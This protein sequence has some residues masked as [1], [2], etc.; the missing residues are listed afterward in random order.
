[1]LKW[2][3]QNK[4]G[5]IIKLMETLKMQNLIEYIAE[6]SFEEVNVTKPI[7][8]CTNKNMFIEEVNLIDVKNQELKA[9]KDNLKRKR[10]KHSLHLIN[11]KKVRLRCS[12]DGNYLK[13]VSILY[14]FNYFDYKSWPATQGRAKILMLKNDVRDYHYLHEYSIERSKCTTVGKRTLFSQNVTGMYNCEC[15]RHIFMDELK[16]TVSL[17]IVLQLLQYWTNLGYSIQTSI[18]KLIFCRMY[19]FYFMSWHGTQCDS[20]IFSNLLFPS[21]F[22]RSQLSKALKPTSQSAGTCL[23]IIPGTV[24]SLSHSSISSTEESKTQRGG[25]HIPTPVE[26]SGVMTFAYTSPPV[27]Y[28]CRQ[29]S[30]APNF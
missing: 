12:I 18:R 1:M 2:N 29:R 8:I 24:V 10:L 5:Q 25:Y 17:N 23:D 20:S 11:Q 22:D 21:L 3:G 15:D 28:V 30:H 6:S 4:E 27:K 16:L 9:R 13:K 7:F 14:L 19:N 26:T